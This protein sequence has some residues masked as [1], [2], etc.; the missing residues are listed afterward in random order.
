VPIST[1]AAATPYERLRGHLQGRVLLQLAVDGN[2]QVRQ[3]AVARSSGDPVLD[4]HALQLVEGWRF[5]VPADHP[6]GVSGA[7]PMRFDTG[8]GLART[9]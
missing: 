6:D 7:L 1:P 2:G 4:R 8:A 3:A 5:A 9:P